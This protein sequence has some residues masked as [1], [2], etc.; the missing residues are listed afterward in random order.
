MNISS[1]KKSVYPISPITS[2]MIIT[3]KLKIMKYCQSFEKVKNTKNI[4]EEI[5]MME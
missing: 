5:G 4:I 2:V 1:T 3:K